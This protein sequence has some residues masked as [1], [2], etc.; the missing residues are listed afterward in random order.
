MCVCESCT[1]CQPT[2]TSAPPPQASLLNPRSMGVGK[3]SR[4]A[5]KFQNFVLFY[6][7]RKVGLIYKNKE[8]IMHAFVCSFWSSS[9]APFFYQSKGF[10]LFKQI[11]SSQFLIEN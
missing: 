5:L 6:E 11:A 8:K 2:L 10:I 9:L 1:P 3:H 4:D 7:E